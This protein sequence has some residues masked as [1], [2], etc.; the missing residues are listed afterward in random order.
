M[1]MKLKYISNNRTTVLR[2]KEGVS[3]LSY[4]VLADIPWLADGFSTRLGGVSEGIYA[5]MNLNFNVGDDHEKVVENF[6]RMGAA[7]GIDPEKMVFSQQTHTTNVMAVDEK[8]CG[9]GI[10]RERSYRD[11]DGI[12][13]DTPG[14]CLVTSYADC[15]PLYFVDP[16]HRAVGLSH[17]GWRGTVGNIAAA[18]IEL[19]EQK[20]QTA[21]HDLIVCIG[22]SICQDCYEVSED[23]ALKFEE[24]YDPGEHKEILKKKGGQKYLLNLHNACRLNLLHAGVSGKNI[25]MPDLC[26]CCNP[27]IL[28]SHRA[29]KGRRGGLCAFL[30]IRE[31]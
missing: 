19:M 2:E 27:D 3:Y 29:S 16:V 15:V 5:A 14:I 18:T 13:T 12:V 4:K 9:M 24:V 30:G 20:F 7:I 8:H 6:R 21:P 25:V 22:P 11:I 31:Y 10:L 1:D 17:S 26:T 28:F 23:V